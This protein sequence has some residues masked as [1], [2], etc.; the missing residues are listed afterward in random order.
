M[1]SRFDADFSDPG[2]NVDAFIDEVFAELK[3]GFLELPKGQGFIEYPTFEAGYQ[4]LKKATTNFTAVDAV[5]VTNAIYATPIVFTVLR[6]ILG[7]TP[8]EWADVTTERT[9][10]AVDQ[11]AA[12][13]L[14][15]R[16]RVAPMVPL[17]DKGSVTD[18]RLKAMIAAAIQMLELGAGDVDRALIL[19]RL[20]KVD[21]AA[22]MASIRPIADLGVPYPVLL[23]ERFLGRPFAAHRDSVSELVGDVVESAV[24]DVLSKV[25]VSYRKTK[26]AERITGFDQAPDFIIPDEFNPAV[27]I[28][29]KLTE[30][31]GTARDKV[32][33]V[34]R[35]RTLRDEKGLTYDVVACIAGRGFKV[36]RNDMRRL[37]IATE[38][39][40]F[41]LASIENLVTQTR[42][43]DY[44]TT[45]IK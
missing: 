41:T 27:I 31:D 35:L 21:T 36:R 45:P 17:K 15:R 4:V 9:E 42:I 12:R 11:G 1:P 13:T 29:A 39:K 30:D 28:E 34:Q 26:R 5:A 23:Y 40:V 43:R 33:R 16:I 20:D 8:S 3:S 6:T 2:L 38:G 18:Q 22:G 37:L 19:H 44:V 7:F 14:D 24:E 32:T 10:V 25:S